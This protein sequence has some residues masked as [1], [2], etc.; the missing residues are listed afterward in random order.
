MRAKFKGKLKLTE[1]D[2]P[3][4]YT[5]HFEGQGGAAGHAKGSARVALEAVAERETRLR[6]TAEASIGGKLAQIGSRLVDAAAKKVANDFFRNFNEKVG[7]AQGDADATV[8]LAP[9]PK[10]KEHDEH[11]K[12]IPRDPDLPD[13]SNTTL[14][15]FAAGALVVFTVALVVLLH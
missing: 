13:A 9:P 12:P 7:G 15:F 14:M 11:G 6:Y 10:E 5:M 8:I 4:G 1:L 3:N 2:A